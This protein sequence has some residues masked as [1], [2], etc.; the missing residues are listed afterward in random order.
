MELAEK[1]LQLLSRRNLVVLA[2]A[3]LAG[4]PRA[5]IVEINKADKNKLI[6]TDNEMG[7]TCQNL[8]AN[9]KVFLLAFKQDYNY[10]L[11]ISGEAE[12]HSSG[13]YFDFV[14]NLET[15]KKTNPKG[16]VV[17]RV[18]EIIEFQ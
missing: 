5:I 3:S 16:A 15:N 12:Y 7:Q 18:K 1:Q 9:K 10:C 8:L 11:K 13:E 6:I 14:K 17:V 2:T 4:E